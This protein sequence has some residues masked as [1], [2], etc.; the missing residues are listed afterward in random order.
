MKG[1]IMVKVTKEEAQLV[2][3]RFPDVYITITGRGKSG[4]RKNRYVE[5]SSRVMALIHSIRNGTNANAKRSGAFA[6]ER[7]VRNGRQTQKA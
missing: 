1:R 4:D 5:E 2:H 7:G 3:K 6:Y